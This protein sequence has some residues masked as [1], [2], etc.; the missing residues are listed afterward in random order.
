MTV[1]LLFANNIVLN[2]GHHDVII[3]C[4]LETI[5]CGYG[6]MSDGIMFANKAFQIETPPR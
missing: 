4:D 3:N 2:P 6:L 1:V 5:A